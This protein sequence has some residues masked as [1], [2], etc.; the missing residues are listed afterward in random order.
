MSIRKWIFCIMPKNEVKFRQCDENYK[1][2]VILFSDSIDSNPMFFIDIF[3]LIVICF[4]CSVIYRQPRAVVGYG[5]RF[6]Y[7]CDIGCQ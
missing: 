4:A 2:F 1:I 5:I 6:A 7:G 3:P